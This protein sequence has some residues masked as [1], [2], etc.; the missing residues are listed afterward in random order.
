MKTKRTIVCGLF[1]VLL[2]LTGA[3]MVFAQEEAK[4]EAEETADSSVK[5]NA[6]TL[7]T[8]PLFKGF[9]ASNSDDDTFFFCMAFAYERLILPHFTIGAELDMY[10]G[11]F[12]DT[13]YFYF[14]LAATGRFYPM[15]EYM[16]RF[17][18][19]ASLGINTQAVDGKTNPDDGGFFGLTIGLRAGY[20]LLLGDLFF[21]E[22]SM[23][24]TYA[25]TDGFLFGMTPQNI[26]WQA[27]LRVGVSF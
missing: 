8:I 19:G 21:I 18:M 13:S 23:A 15:S 26:G 27:G 6:V 4:T 9:I 12:W 2:T 22:P 17:F 20:R 10:P 11:K 16:E 1:A 3:G 14:G 7:D 5:S 25:K 24:Y